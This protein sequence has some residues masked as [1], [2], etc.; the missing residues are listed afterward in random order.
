M[1]F[2]FLEIQCSSLTAPTN[3]RISY[4]IDT[5]APFD[6]GTTATYQCNPGFGLN[7]GNRERSCGGLNQLGEWS[8]VAPTCERKNTYI[9][10]SHFIF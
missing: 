10:D 1:I 9:Q 6:F 8:G 7:R 5:T 4:A 3:G 2:L